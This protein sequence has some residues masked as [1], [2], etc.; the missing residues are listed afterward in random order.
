MVLLSPRGSPVMVRVELLCSS[1]WHFVQMKN[2]RLRGSSSLSRS[3]QV[4][5]L[6][7]EALLIPPTPT[8]SY[9]TDYTGLVQSLSPA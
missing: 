8:P 2:L 9:Q 5:K 1:V 6:A 3:W 7:L 4:A